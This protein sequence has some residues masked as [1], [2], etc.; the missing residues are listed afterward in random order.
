VTELL[1][2]DDHNRS[3]SG[4]PYF[5]QPKPTGIAC[6]ECSSELYDTNPYSMLLSDPPQLAVHCSK[7]SY[8][9]YRNA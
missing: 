3:R 7:C 5:R 9:G 4:T 2:L 1:S 6:P 8:L